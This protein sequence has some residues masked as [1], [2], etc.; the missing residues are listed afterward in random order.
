MTHPN[1]QQPP[2]CF[3]GWGCNVLSLS[4]SKLSCLAWFSLAWRSLAYVSALHPQTLKQWGRS[5]VFG[6][7]IWATLKS[8]HSVH[9]ITHQSFAFY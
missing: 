3:K 1:A 9:F 2:E 7:L 4:L 6:C 5:L 8:H